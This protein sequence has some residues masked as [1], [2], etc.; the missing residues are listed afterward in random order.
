MI[1]HPAGCGS[2][3]A[4]SSGQ[5]VEIGVSSLLWLSWLRLACDNS[6]KQSGRL[7]TQAEQG[8]PAPRVRPPPKSRR[9][10]RQSEKKKLRQCRKRSFFV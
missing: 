4:G 1:D 5:T 10:C 2:T 6:G 7:Q 8:K 3:A 9:R